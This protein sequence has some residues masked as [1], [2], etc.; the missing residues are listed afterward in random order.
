MKLTEIKPGQKF[1]Y[2]NAQ[3]IM[4]AAYSN[5]NERVGC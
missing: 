2:C 4:T 1:T 5:D 3:F